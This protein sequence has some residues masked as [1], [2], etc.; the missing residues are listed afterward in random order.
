MDMTTVI[1]MY[2]ATKLKLW[3]GDRVLE[4]NR[5][6]WVGI[7]FSAWNSTVTN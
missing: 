6:C 5:K 1:C 4:G 7:G 3:C 2:W